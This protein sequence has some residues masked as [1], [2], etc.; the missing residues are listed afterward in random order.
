MANSVIRIRKKQFFLYK[1]MPEFGERIWEYQTVSSYY[2]RIGLLSS[3]SIESFFWEEFWANLMIR[4][5]SQSKYKKIYDKE[6][7]QAYE[8]VLNVYSKFFC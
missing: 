2:S 5:G 6:N 7:G 1:V 3:K 8:I 4:C